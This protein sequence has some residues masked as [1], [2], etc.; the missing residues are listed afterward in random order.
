MFCPYCHLSATNRRDAA[1]SMT[2]PWYFHA[3]CRGCGS[4]IEV[5][6]H[7][8]PGKIG[9][10]LKLASKPNTQSDEPAETTPCQ[11]PDALLQ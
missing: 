5:V 10:I 8:P 4:K 3:T 11:I 2:E 1:K 7:P 6:F 9:T